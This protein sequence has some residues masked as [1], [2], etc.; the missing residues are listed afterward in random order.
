M[1]ENLLREM[2]FLTYPLVK[3]DLHHVISNRRKLVKRNTFKYKDVSWAGKC[4][5]NW[6][7]Y[8]KEN[9]KD[10]DMDEDS[11]YS[12]KDIS[13][14]MLDISKVVSTATNVSPLAIYSDKTNKQEG[15]NPMDIEDE[16]TAMFPKR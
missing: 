2:E 9:P 14:A 7:D 3:Y 10:V 16:D 4:F 15:S 8:L 5:Y 12:V 13:S 11:N 1:I 6:D